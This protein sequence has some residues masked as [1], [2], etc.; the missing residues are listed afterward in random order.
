MKM[1][2][3]F[4]KRKLDSHKGDYGKV[5]ILAG[6]PGMLGAAILASRAALRCGAGLV[7][8]GAPRSQRDIVNLATPE[9]IVIGGDSAGDFLTASLNADAVAIGP[10]LGQR[11]N[12]A[13]DLLSRLSRAK[14]KKP[15][16]LDADAITAY[17]NDLHALARLN[18]NLILTP[19]PGEMGKLFFKSAKDIQSDRSGFA[20]NLSKLAG[21]VTVLKGHNTLISNRSGAV[22]TNKTGNPGMSTAGAG[23]VLTGMIASFA[24]QG[25]DPN[26][27][28]RSGVYIHGLAGDLAQK[29]VGEYGMIASD[30]IDMIPKAIKKAG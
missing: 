7:Y 23:D 29:E 27:A 15:V 8:L 2:G 28:A 25:M 9:V 13:K 4:P 19:H 20:V 1:R 22:S 5:F 10:G 26:D 3:I 21:C 11:S 24:A 17:Q 12:I 14:Y 30:I 16:I 18:L 6:S